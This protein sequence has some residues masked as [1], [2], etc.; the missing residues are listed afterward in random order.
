[1][2]AEEYLT[3]GKLEDYCLGLLTPKEEREV[4]AM[5]EAYPLVHKELQALHQALEAYAIR[6]EVRPQKELRNTV[7]AAVKRLWEGAG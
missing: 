3:S 2:N 7:W 5:C 4:E 1:M 6:D